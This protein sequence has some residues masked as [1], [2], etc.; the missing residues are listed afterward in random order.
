MPMI[1]VEM[2]EGRT[3]EQKRNL[4]KALT[5]SFIETCGGKPEQVQIVIQDISTDDWAAAGVLATD[6]IAAAEKKA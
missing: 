4:A 1:R 5:D 3:I 6:R 2:Y